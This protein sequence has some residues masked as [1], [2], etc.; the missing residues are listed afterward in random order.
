[1]NDSNEPSYYEV[2]LTNRQVLVSF[3]ILLGCVL[4]AFVSGVY[5]GRQAEPLPEV[6]VTDA[7][8]GQQPDEVA[9]LE[10]FKFF[11]E[12]GSGEGELEKPDLSSL[13]EG[14]KAGEKKTLAEDLGSAPAPSSTPPSSTPPSSSPP[15]S[16]PPSSTPPPTSP[17]SS[18]PRQDPP[19]PA[20]PPPPRVGS[21]PPAAAV[22]DGFIIQVF[23]SRDED[24][25]EKVLARL[26]SGGYQAFLSP[27]D[28]GG[29]TMYRVRIGPFARRPQ[30][31]KVGADIHQKYKLETWI[32]A[33]SN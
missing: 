6:E 9:K 29:I 16:S 30:A 25:A 17:P 4:A 28:Q 21:P 32:T 1:M 22:A 5:V 19:P 23:S 27:L 2:A 18:P 12:E 15:S 8:S 13:R 24:Q 33:A 31:E 26:K 3:V 11:D 20:S 10:E 14:E 7:P